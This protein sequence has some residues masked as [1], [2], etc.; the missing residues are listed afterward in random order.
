MREVEIAAYTAFKDEN[1]VP[2]RGDIARALN[3][4][5]SLFYVMMFRAKTGE[6]EP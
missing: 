5:S 4:L 2:T 1:G 6:Y 3:R